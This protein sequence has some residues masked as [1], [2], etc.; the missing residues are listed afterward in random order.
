MD[1]KSPEIEALGAMVDS[2]GDGDKSRVGLIS[3]LLSS[4]AFPPTSPVK[5][6]AMVISLA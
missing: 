3:F 6:A 2:G 4:R 5:A 1:K